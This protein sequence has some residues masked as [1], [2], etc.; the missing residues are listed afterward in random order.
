VTVAEAH[1]G[2]MLLGS[3]VTQP[4]VFAVEP[5]HVSRSA[6]IDAKNQTQAIYWPFSDR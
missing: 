2:L 3:I 6:V 1:V 4:S 5:V